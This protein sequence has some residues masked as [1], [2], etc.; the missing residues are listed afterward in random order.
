MIQ[1]KQKIKELCDQVYARNHFP[2]IVIDLVQENIEPLLHPD[3]PLRRDDVGSVNY[4][5]GLIED[6]LNPSFEET[7]VWLKE[8]REQIDIWNNDI[9]WTN[10]VLGLPKES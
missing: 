2:Q 4:H 5:I 3:E 7:K 8:M 10:S 9:E 6:I 1:Y